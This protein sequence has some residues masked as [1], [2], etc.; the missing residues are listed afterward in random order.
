M[1]NKKNYSQL[2]YSSH[3]MRIIHINIQNNYFILPFANN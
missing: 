1:Y 2:I 3:L